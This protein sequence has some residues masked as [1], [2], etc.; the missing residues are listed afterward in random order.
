MSDNNNTIPGITSD[1]TG[2]IPQH[3]AI[4]KWE[5]YT[6]VNTCHLYNH[7]KLSANWETKTWRGL[8]IQ[9]GQ[10]KSSVRSLAQETGLTFSQVRTALTNLT[11]KTNYILTTP[12]GDNDT[13]YTIIHYEDVVKM[14]K[15]E[16][17]VAHLEEQN[18]DENT[19]TYS[20]KNSDDRTLNSTLESIRNRTLDDTPNSTLLSTPDS[21]PIAHGIA[22]QSHTISN[23]IKNIY[24]SKKERREDDS[25]PE[26]ENLP[27]LK[28][29]IPRWY[30]IIK[31]RWPDIPDVQVN[32]SYGKYLANHPKFHQQSIAT[33]SA[34]VENEKPEK[35]IKELPVS[36]QK[37]SWKWDEL[38]EAKIKNF[39][40]RKLRAELYRIRGEAIF[41][42]WLNHL[43]FLDEYQ[44]LLRLATPTRFICD[45]INS[46][47]L[48]SI[49]D[50]VGEINPAIK[51]IE[52]IIQPEDV[53]NAAKSAIN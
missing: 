40:F 31:K 38:E 12:S 51:K 39:T 4:L 34:W 28:N 1:G 14:P 41:K 16:G 36:T 24:N 37:N 26:D 10:Y 21:T 29:D 8:T 3:R 20:D 22:N 7:I 6:D 11:D 35:W 19:D 13:L 15:K 49:E 53:T 33:W 42:N 50:I 25:L 5:W 17:G 27:D 23:N 48:K 32:I 18:N 44:N 45:E 43:K 46:K 9:R 47:Y 2:W 52:I 30:K